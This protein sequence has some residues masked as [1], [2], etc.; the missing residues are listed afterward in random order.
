MNLWHLAI[1]HAVAES[2][3]VSAGAAQLHVSQP[4]V[5]RQLRQL[6]TALG[7]TLLD[8][9]PRGVRLTESGT[10]LH[11][12]AQRIFALEQEAEIAIREIRQLNTGELSIG[13]SSTIGNYLLP[14]L[15]AEYRRRYPGVE[16]SVEISNTHTIEANL[17]NRRLA[18]GL[19]EGRLA[20]PELHAEV[21]L[22]DQIVPIA[23]ARH[24]LTRQRRTSI[25]ALLQETL[26]QRETGSGTRDFV[27]QML[28][29][30]HLKF[31]RAICLGSTEAIKK[32]VAAGGGVAFVSLLAIETE[33][34]AR[35]L[36]ILA[37]PELSRARPLHWV[38]L[39]RRHLPTAAMSFLAL[40]S[41]TAM[42]PAAARS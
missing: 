30:R 15:L 9:L 7:S 42:I 40:L 34:R 17:L 21:F 14:P 25:Q 33:L 41:R 32:M 39:H 35:T 1:F 20:S 2:G 28:Q 31:A 13:A 4:A 27:D 36:K 19:T 16:I 24:P 26:L 23:S 5:T 12:Y 37:V 8:R 3:S 6:E 11:D 29:H 18:L 38:R 22:Q 10:L